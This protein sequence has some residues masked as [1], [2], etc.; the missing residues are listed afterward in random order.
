MTMTMTTTT[1]SDYPDS[2][3]IMY[4]VDWPTDDP[5]A[6]CTLFYLGEQQDANFTAQDLFDAL[7]EADLEAPGD[8]PTAGLELFG[9]EQDTPVA[10]LDS[11]LLRFQ[12]KSLGRVLKEK[13]IEDA[14]SFPQYR[15]HVTLMNADAEI[16]PTINLGAPQVWW[17]N[18]RLTK[19]GV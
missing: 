19:D 15:P 8:V 10:L 11:L 3:G 5:Q 9:E 7:D 2:I 16:P 4:P 18:E 6:H 14:S 17:G 12:K 1:A 13:G